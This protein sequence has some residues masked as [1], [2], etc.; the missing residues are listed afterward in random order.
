MDG[1]VYLGKPSV[2]ADVVLDKFEFVRPSQVPERF[3]KAAKDGA[4]GFGPAQSCK[5]ILQLKD[6]A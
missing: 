1:T 6:D 4:L 2:D 5:R 3:A